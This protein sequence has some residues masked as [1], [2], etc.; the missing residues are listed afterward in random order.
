VENAHITP[1]TTGD[2]NLKSMFGH[3]VDTS[4]SR[5]PFSKKEEAGCQLKFEPTMGTVFAFQ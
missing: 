3:V 4:R 2:P 1:T 5:L